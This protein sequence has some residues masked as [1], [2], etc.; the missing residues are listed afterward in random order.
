MITRLLE[1]KIL[2]KLNSGKAIILLGPRQTGKTTL[3]EKIAGQT[4]KYLLIDCDDS[5]V[6]SQMENANT[7]DIRRIIGNH[8]TVFFDE[9]Q[10][11][12]NIGLV[13]K[14]ITDKFKDVQLLVSGS[15]SLDLLSE[16]NEPLTGRKWE[17][18]LYPISWAEFSIYAGQL[19]SIQQLETR[20][21]FGMYPEV[22]NKQ[23][24]ERETL[25]QLSGS[26]LYKDLLSYQG[27]RKPDLLEKLLRAVA[28]QTGS[29]VSYSELASLLQV[30]RKTIITYLDLLEKAFVI[31]R[32]QAF[33][34]NLRNEIT[35]T[36]KIYFY[37]TGIRNALLAN[38]NPLNIRQDT[39]AL[40]ENFLISERMKHLHYNGIWANCFFW[41]TKDRQEIDYLEERE[42]K[43]YA[44][45]FKWNPVKKH[46]FPVTFLN[47]YPGSS[48]ELISQ[49]NFS[50]FIS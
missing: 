15:S 30:D 21:L 20:I 8:K 39:G 14:I 40:W 43:L 1:E 12:K 25:R 11:I 22:I 6:R 49:D 27:I 32:L 18:Y 31:F 7:E 35:S 29:E 36:R 4:G 17:Y 28:L 3:L 10:R 50:D 24:N 34:G 46:R 13:L 48:A 16:I 41:R 44:F 38:F 45:E 26:F 19:K 23:G 33:S 2:S 37:D 42:G 47:A 5:M 9:A